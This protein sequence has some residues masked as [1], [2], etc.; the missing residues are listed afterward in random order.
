MTLRGLMLVKQLAV[1][2]PQSNDAAQWELV[3]GWDSQQAALTKGIAFDSK[4]T[5]TDTFAGAI[6][7]ECIVEAS[8]ASPFAYGAGSVTDGKIHRG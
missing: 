8:S 5:P 1:Y 3:S 7:S 4:A 6:G 2:H